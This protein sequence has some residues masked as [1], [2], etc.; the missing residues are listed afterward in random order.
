MNERNDLI[1]GFVFGQYNRA[2][3]VSLIQ[4][5]MSGGQRVGIDPATGKIYAAALIG[6]IAPGAG[7]QADGMVSA[8]NPGSLPN[9]L[10]QDRGVQWGPRLGFAYDVFG[11]GKTAVRGGFGLF[12][13]R[14]TGGVPYFFSFVGQPPLAY[15]PSVTYGQISS[16]GSATS[17]LSPSTVYAPDLA[18][19]VASVM[20]FSLSVQR[21]IGFQTVVDVG[22]Q[23]SLGRHLQWDVDHNAVPI[24]ADFL[25]SNVDPTTGKVLPTNFLRPIPG[26][27]AIYTPSFGSSS[28]Y[29]ALQVTARRRFSKNF[30]FGAA[31]TWSKAM[32]FADTDNTNVESI[33]NPHSYYY[34]KAA[35]DR[36]HNLALSYIYDLPKSPWRNVVASRVLD[37]WELSGITI[38]QSG[39][40][41]GVT[42]TTTNGE[43]I[44]G[45]ASLAPR[46]NLIADPVLPKSQRNF[47]ENFNVAALQL[48]AVGSLGNAAPTF[49]RGP[50]IENFDLALI[51]NVT[52]YER[53]HIQLR[54]A[55]FNTFNHTQFTT[56]NTAAQFNPATGQQT[57]SKLGAF[58]AAA[59]PRQ[60][61]LGIK[62]VF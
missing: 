60:M 24:G 27:A 59:D 46:V 48:P 28:N 38:F 45:T 55:T 19:K 17:L 49:F 29:N 52:V 56:L 26:Y 62:V 36:T 41:L 8:A 39:Q 42:L 47:N 5:V 20:N 21:D 15:S 14:P 22:Y 4:P 2:Q 54:V 61:Q 10:V 16:L 12:Y 44:T 51:K 9:S 35:F 7:N 50:G 57:N 40:P 43:D 1:S 53:L 33:V 18:G 31:W 3:A 30:Q 32:D 11:D 25:S 58:T 23:A 34:G 6:A 37:R 13:N